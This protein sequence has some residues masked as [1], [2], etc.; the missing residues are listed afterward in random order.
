MT[1][2]DEHMTARQDRLDALRRDRELDWADWKAAVDE[3]AERESVEAMETYWQ[4]VMAQ[5]ADH[6]SSDQHWS[7]T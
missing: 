7:G 5:G 2:D 6:Y 4:G 3:R 1:L